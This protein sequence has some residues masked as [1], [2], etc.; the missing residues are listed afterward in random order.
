MKIYELMEEEQESMESVLSEVVPFL[1]DYKDELL[2]GKFLFRGVER[3]SPPRQ[4]F[5]KNTRMDMPRSPRD[6]TRR[7]H[8]LFDKFLNDQFGFKYRSFGKFATGNQKAAST[9]GVPHI[10]LPIGNFTICYSNKIED[11]YNDIFAF[12]VDLVKFLKVQVFKNDLEAF[13]TKLK[14]YDLMTEDEYEDSLTV[15]G[16]SNDAFR[17]YQTFHAAYDFETEDPKILD[18]YS[19]FIEEVLFANCGYAETTDYMQA[20]DAL[21]EVMVDCKSYIMID[22]SPESVERFQD[23]VRDL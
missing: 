3:H 22:S 10:F 13:G 23:Y 21:K 7:D 19:R 2:R 12:F 16:M 8:A 9:Y 5:V 17:V 11:P 14:E 1:K 6:I 4:F 20:A 15:R 18:G